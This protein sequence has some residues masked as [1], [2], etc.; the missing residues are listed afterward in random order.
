M[1]L[2]LDDDSANLVL[3]KLPGREGHD[4]LIPA[5]FKLTGAKDPS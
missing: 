2:Y 5:D 1:R 3:V 4:V